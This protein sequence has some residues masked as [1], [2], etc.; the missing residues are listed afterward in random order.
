MLAHSRRDGNT[1]CDDESYWVDCNSNGSQAQA[2][3]RLVQR[4]GRIIFASVARHGG[5]G[6]VTKVRM[7]QHVWDAANVS[8]VVVGTG[9]T[10]YGFSKKHA[11]SEKVAA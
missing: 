4:R 10:I 6:V 8:L 9:A 1:F 5:N 11:S 3:T 2:R 7:R